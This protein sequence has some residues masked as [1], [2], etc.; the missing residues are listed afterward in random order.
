MNKKHLTH[1]LMLFI[2]LAG[3]R[4]DS[5]NDENWHRDI[6]DAQGM[7]VYTVFANRTLHNMSIVYGNHLAMDWKAFASGHLRAGTELTIV[8][9]QEENNK[10]WYGSYINGPIKSIEQLRLIKPEAGAQ[11]WTYTLLR[12]ENPSG[13]GGGQLSTFGRIQEI[14]S[15]PPIVFP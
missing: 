12:G 15:K 8:T 7:Q 2:A 5:K 9:Y 13:P 11:G 4:H 3:C 14:L 6:F 1:L 10:Y